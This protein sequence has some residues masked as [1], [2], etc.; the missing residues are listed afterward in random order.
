MSSVLPALA[1]AMLVIGT[2]TV[3]DLSP[4]DKGAVIVV[5]DPGQSTDEFWEALDAANA[6]LL[7]K[8]SAPGSYL[9]WSDETGLPER[10]RAAGARVVM[11]ADGSAMCRSA[12]LPSVT[13]NQRI[14]S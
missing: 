9:V 10:L 4:P 8:S 1:L 3:A 2:I 12:D 11:N 5:F 14:Q 6:Y 7:S 13:L